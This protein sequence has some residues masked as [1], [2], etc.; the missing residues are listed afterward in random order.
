MAQLA[1]SVEALNDVSAQRCV[2]NVMSLLD[3]LVE[4]QWPVTR[5]WLYTIT[6]VLC[7]YCTWLCTVRTANV[8][9]NCVSSLREVA[10]LSRHLRSLHQDVCIVEL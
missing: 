6:H 7:L 5:D 3:E 8:A 2:Q 1:V 4:Q 9:P 10:S